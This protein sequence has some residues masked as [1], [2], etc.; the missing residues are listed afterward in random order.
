M[1]LDLS[2][3]G[4]I[5]DSHDVFGDTKQ[6]KPVFILQAGDQGDRK[7]LFSLKSS[8]PHYLPMTEGKKG[9]TLIRACQ[10]ELTTSA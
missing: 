6:Q 9:G 1:K 4:W 2:Q 10:E 3:K 8:Y 7:Q 5:R